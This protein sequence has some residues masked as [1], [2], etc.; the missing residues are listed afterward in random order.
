MKTK[1]IVYEKAFKFS[2]RIVN[3]YKYLKEN[4]HEYIMSKQLMRCG[5]SIGANIAEGLEGQSKKDFIAKLYIALKES[6]E[7][8]YWINLLTATGYLEPNEEESLEK[9]LDEIIKMLTSII[10]T[11]KS[12]TSV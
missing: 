7:S 6:S 2:I 10:K 5:T 4:K 8:R 12:N 1:S 11:A 9:D 3:L